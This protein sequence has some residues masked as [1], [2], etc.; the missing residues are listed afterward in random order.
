M[1]IVEQ[2]RAIL[3]LLGAIYCGETLAQTPPTAEARMIEKNI[4]LPAV[5][6]QLGNYVDAVKTGNLVFVSGSTSRGWKATGQ[7]G[8]EVSTE[9]GYR[10]ARHAG[11]ITLAKLKASIESLDKVRRVVKVVGLVNAS[12]GFADHP[13]VVNG[14]SDL[15]VEVFGEKVGP[16]ARTSVGIS[17]LPRN[18]PVE[19]ELIVEV[20]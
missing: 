3:A 11:L 9:E 19:V 18:A 12:E 16:H 14:F 10:A 7:V 1:K 6:T 8:K 17:S 5:P 4:A 2:L 15:L 20:E 13:K